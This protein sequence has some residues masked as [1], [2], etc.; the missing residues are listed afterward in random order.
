MGNEF[1][2]IS[3]NVRMVLNWWPKKCT[4]LNIYPCIQI[5]MQS[6]EYFLV[7]NVAEHDGRHDYPSMWSFLWSPKQKKMYN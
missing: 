1:I 7:W 6:V 2:L 4:Y 5:K 3:H